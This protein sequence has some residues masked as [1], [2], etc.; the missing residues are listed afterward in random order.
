MKRII[1]ESYAIRNPY[2]GLGEF[3]MKLGRHIAA[4]AEELRTQHQIELY[5][6]VPPKYKGC[7]GNQVHYLAVPKALRYILMAY[8]FRVDLFH[9]PHQYCHLKKICRA[10]NVLMTIHD[11]NFMYEKQGEKLDRS[12]RR[13]KNKLHLVSHLNYISQFAKTDTNAHFPAHFP[14]RVIYNGVPDLNSKAQASEAFA[15]RLPEHF[16]FH[17]SSLL[18]K[19]NIHLLVEMMKHLPEENLVIAGNWKSSYGQKL[20]EQI[21]AEHIT[22]ILPLNNVSEEEKAYLYKRCKAFVFPSLC[23][24]FGLPPIEAMKFGKPCFLSTCTSLPEIGG[25]LAYYWPVL[26]PEEMAT[27]VREQISSPDFES[28]ENGQ[29]IRNYAQ[30]FDWEKCAQGYI[31]YYLDILNSSK[32]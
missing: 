11:I 26:Q 1:I 24:G 9:M 20:L 23:E 2:V 16:L 14:D 27:V 4:H 32:K 8:P 30:K 13:F 18:P 25:E 5:F 15:S 28:P 10:E 6:I 22:N 31:D 3:C 29:R 21:K 19:K 7:F 12:I 17:I